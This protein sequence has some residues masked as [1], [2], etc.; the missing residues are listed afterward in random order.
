M[1]SRVII[2]K[3][4]S[5]QDQF[6]GRH[7]VTIAW[8]VFRRNFFA[9]IVTCN[10]VQYLAVYRALGCSAD[11]FVDT[12]SLTFVFDS[13]SSFSEIVDEVFGLGSNV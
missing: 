1:K 12:W 8:L 13:N 10:S 3:E 2:Y 5:K 11:K 7:I 4:T 6:E 9:D